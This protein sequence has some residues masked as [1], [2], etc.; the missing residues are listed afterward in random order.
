MTSSGDRLSGR[1]DLVSP[2]VDPDS[3]TIKV[4]VEVTDYPPSTRPGDFVEVSI[5]TDRH[6]DSLLVPRVAV[7]TERG[8]RSVYVAEEGVARQR[9]VEMGFE[10]DLYAEILSGLDDGELVI[11]Q[12]QRSLRDSQPISILDAIDLDG[13]DSSPSTSEEPTAG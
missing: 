10:D 8:Q 2:L 12:G 1:I 11:V 6:D 7:V 3:G 13:E 5:V 9:A 4:T